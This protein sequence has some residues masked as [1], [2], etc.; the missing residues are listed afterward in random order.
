MK[1]EDQPVSVE[2]DAQKK[3]M[4]A[5]WEHLQSKHKL[6]DFIRELLVS[7]EIYIVDIDRRQKQ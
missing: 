3:Q 5:L 6:P 1:V 7:K 4:L 2:D